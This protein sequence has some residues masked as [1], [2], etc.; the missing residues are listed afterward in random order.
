MKLIYFK[1]KAK[2]DYQIGLLK[3]NK[4]LYLSEFNYLYRY[5][6]SKIYKMNDIKSTHK[7]FFKDSLIQIKHRILAEDKI[8]K[9][10]TKQSKFVGG[11]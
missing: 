9:I 4:V 5:P 6:L 7:V 2:D 11:K 8:Q 10:H 1:L 3:D